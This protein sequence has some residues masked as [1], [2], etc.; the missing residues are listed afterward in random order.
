MRRFGWCVIAAATCLAAMGCAE[1]AQQN[2]NNG[3][4]LI[5]AGFHV[6][7]ADTPQRQASLSQLPPQKFVRKLRG[8]K[9]AFI[10]ADPANCNCAYVGNV[11]TYAAYQ[12]H[13]ARQE[14]AVTTMDDWDF[15]PW[16]FGYPE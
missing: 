2:A 10:Y 16:A 6:V 1:K 5:A 8:D 12:S 14:Q 4:A 9:V 3:S 7:P 15:S 13:L 11:S